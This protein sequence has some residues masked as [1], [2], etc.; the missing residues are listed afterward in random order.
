[1]LQETT[2]SIA[3]TNFPLL[4]GLP[5]VSNKSPVLRRWIELRFIISD[6]DFSLSTGTAYSLTVKIF[7]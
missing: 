4:K 1:M 5:V 6:K 7:S 2:G 3:K